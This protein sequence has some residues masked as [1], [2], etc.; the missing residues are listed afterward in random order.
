[1]RTGEKLEGRPRQVDRLTRDKG[2]KGVIVVLG[3]RIASRSYASS[4][5]DFIPPCTLR[6]SSTAKAGT[7]D[8]E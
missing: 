4:Y 3:R 1:M 8:V 6:H 5:M 2:D 7:M